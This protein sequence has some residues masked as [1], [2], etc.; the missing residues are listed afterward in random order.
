MRIKISLHSNLNPARGE[1][2]CSEEVEDGTREAVILEDGTARRRTGAV[3]DF[4][5]GR[6]IGRPTLGEGISQGGILE[7]GHTECRHRECMKC[8]SKAA[9]GKQPVVVEW[10]GKDTTP[11]TTRA[12]TP[13]TILTTT[14]VT[15]RVSVGAD[16]MGTERWKL[17]KYWMKSSKASRET[18]KGGKKGR[19]SPP[20]EKGF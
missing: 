15:I 11:I 7:E 3:M 6:H 19:F 1:V 9:S 12:T 2:G 18:R 4:R 10:R 17:L 13:T 20:L 8:T 5:P 14:P 16:L